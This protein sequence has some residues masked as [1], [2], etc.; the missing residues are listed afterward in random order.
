MN[1][2]HSDTIDPGMR[3]IDF[4]CRPPIAPQKLLFDVK[5]GRL[6]ARNQFNIVVGQATSPSMYQ[7][8]TA[9]G[10]SLLKQEMDAAGVDHILMPGRNVATTIKALEMLSDATSINVTD[11]MLLEIGAQFDGRATGLHGINLADIPQSVKDIEVAVR[12][13]GMPGAV[14]ETGYVRKANGEPLLLD[15]PSLYPL[16]ETLVSLDAV[17]MIQSGIY[18]G[19]DIGVNDWPPLDRVLQEFPTLKVVLAHGGYPRVL[20][21]LALAVKHQN[22]YLS[23]DIYCFFPGGQLYVDAISMLPD[24]FIFGTAYPFAPLKESV[25]ESLKFPLADDVMEKYMGGNAARLLG[26]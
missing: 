16:Y 3:V 2:D 21:A 15:D 4:R 25:V 13:H 14:L 19:F 1:N 10:L 9:Q 6:Q 26:L 12:E 22:F 8:G 11:G 7:V 23:P 20:D 17:L 18:A 24:Q 5:L